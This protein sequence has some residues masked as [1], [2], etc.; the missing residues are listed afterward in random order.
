[1][2]LEFLID[3]G[4]LRE[5]C[6]LG[7]SSCVTERGQERVLHDWAEKDVGAEVLGSRRDLA[8]KIV[9]RNFLVADEELG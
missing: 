2:A 7:G 1:M 3:D 6:D 8:E 4:R 9:L 5:V